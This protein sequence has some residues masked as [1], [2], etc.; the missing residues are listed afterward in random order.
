M[1]W[2]GLYKSS[3]MT[4]VRSTAGSSV[5]RPWP[6]T[7]GSAILCAGAATSAAPLRCVGVDM[8]REALSH[9][10][11]Q[12]NDDAYLI[13]QLVVEGHGASVGRGGPMANKPP[14]GS[15]ETLLARIDPTPRIYPVYISHA[16]QPHDFAITI[17]GDPDAQPGDAQIHVVYPNTTSALGEQDYM[18]LLRCFASHLLAHAAR[19]EAAVAQDAARSA[20][21]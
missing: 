15:P 9:L 4:L 1:S 16:Q 3:F 18:A 20:E 12:D 2:H 21:P 19:Y 10:L 5:S 11:R 13:V 7:W 6:S 14:Q 17:I 8:L